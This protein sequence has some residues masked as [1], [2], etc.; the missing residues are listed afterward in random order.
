MA[1]Q[2]GRHTIL[3]ETATFYNDSGDVRAVIESLHPHWATP[4]TC[5]ALNP[6]RTRALRTR[7]R[8][9]APGKQRR[10]RF[11]AKSSAIALWCSIVGSVLAA[12]PKAS[13]LCLII[14]SL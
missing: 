11:D 3:S 6:R 13:A 5:Q 14:G 12:N 2:S 10:F 8:G 1:P 9:Q 7:P 4:A